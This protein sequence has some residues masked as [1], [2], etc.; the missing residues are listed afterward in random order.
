MDDDYYLE[1]SIDRD[2]ESLTDWSR[3]SLTRL[4]EFRCLLLHVVYV[5]KVIETAVFI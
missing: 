1:V 5:E 4:S 2:D 3:K